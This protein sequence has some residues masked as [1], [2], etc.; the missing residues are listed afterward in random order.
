MSLFDHTFFI[1]H[2]SACTR[3]LSLRIQRATLREQ[4]NIATICEQVATH[5][6]SNNWAMLS[7]S[8]SQNSIYSRQ[9]FSTATRDSAHVCS[10]TRG[11]SSSTC[12]SRLIINKN[13]EN[14]RKGRRSAEEI[15]EEVVRSEEK[16][17]GG[18][19]F[20]ILWPD[21]T[22]VKRIYPSLCAI[23]AIPPRE[24]EDN[25]CP[26]WTLKWKAGNIPSVL[27]W[28]FPRDSRRGILI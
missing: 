27:L 6:L 11:T 9:I 5:R 14:R 17:N 10:L 8:N 28:N 19:H 3:V 21:S 26:N 22:I 15:G 20:S 7:N 23:H 16:R 25:A 24:K 18:N 12:R 1:I 2:Y 13:R 4:Y